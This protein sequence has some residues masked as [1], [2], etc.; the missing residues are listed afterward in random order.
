MKFGFFITVVLATFISAAEIDICVPSFPEIKDLFELTPFQ[1][2]M[3][4][5]VN[6]IFHCIA[7]VFVGVLSERFGK[8]KM[9]NTGLII[10]S[11]GSV[12]C[13]FAQNY[14]SV[15]F[16][17][18]LQGIGVSAPMILAPIFVFD[19]YKQEQQQKMM[20]ILN[21]VVTLTICFAPAIGSFTS[22]LFGWR[23]NFAILLI[24]SFSSM[25]LNKKFLP[26]HEKI[27]KKA[28]IDL[29]KYGI[30]FKN[31]IAMIYI[32]ACTLGIGLYY[33]FV[34]M[35]PLILI[36]SFGVDLRH[37]GFYQG[38]LTLT[39]G[40]VSIFS[41][42]FV[43]KKMK[44]PIFIISEI[45]ILCFLVGASILV[46]SGNQ[47]PIYITLV[48]MMLSVGAV[49]PI[50]AL[51]VNAINSIPD[52]KGVTSSVLII[53]KWIFAS[54]GIQLSSYFYTDNFTST[55]IVMIVMEILSILLTFYLYKKDKNFRLAIGL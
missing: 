23:A 29:R 30:V 17:R 19:K 35:A 3:V 43:S 8:K 36:K 40:A 34:G 53:A 14:P 42:F 44:F 27:D 24:L 10:F 33:T 52:H 4:L 28:K 20:N 39:F 48:I 7:A 51:Y 6:L 50:N 9:M 22:L 2:E 49:A 38:A 25:L 21:G 26:A 46:F 12:F 1:I 55:G 15:I 45:L 31:K 13:T 11:I 47:E 37:F 54:I 18:I 32:L 41:G 16:G 5:S